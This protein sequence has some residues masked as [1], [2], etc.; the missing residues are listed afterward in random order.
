[1]VKVSKSS[2]LASVGNF[3]LMKAT[4]SKFALSSGSERKSIVRAT[5][6]SV[7]T[8]PRVH[9]ARV[10]PSLRDPTAA[11]FDESAKYI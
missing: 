5:V 1:M 3:P 4:G 6:P 11:N 8:R 9:K 10:W 7:Y 2:K